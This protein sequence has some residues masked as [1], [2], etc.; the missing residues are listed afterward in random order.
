MLPFQIRKKQQQ[1]HKEGVLIYKAKYK[2]GK[3]NNNGP[4]LSAHKLKYVFVYV[5]L[6]V[7][8]FLLF[9]YLSN[10]TLMYVK[11]FFLILYDC[12]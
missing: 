9:E 12:I 2:K 5:I 1:L 6:N 11:A 3:K 8:N 7:F 4:A 10:E